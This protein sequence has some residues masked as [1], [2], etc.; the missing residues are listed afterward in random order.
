[1]RVDSHTEVCPAW[2][3]SENP[4]K[5]LKDKGVR[6]KIDNALRVWPAEWRLSFPM[7]NLKEV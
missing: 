3:I 1:M 5:A 2:P 4:A 6:R 7:R